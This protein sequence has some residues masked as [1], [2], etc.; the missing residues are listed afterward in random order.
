MTPRTT[1][2]ADATSSPDH[3]AGA[4]RRWRCPPEALGPDGEP[5]EAWT[6]HAIHEWYVFAL[7]LGRVLRGMVPGHR[8]ILEDAETGD[9]VQCAR[10]RGWFSEA[11]SNQYIEGFAEPL[12][13]GDM[14]GLR[15]LGWRPP[16]LDARALSPNGAPLK[17]PYTTNW[18]RR[19]LVRDTE[20][21]ADVAARTLGFVYRTG[22]P[23]TLRVSAFSMRGDPPPDL[24]ELC[25]LP[26]DD[27][28]AA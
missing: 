16:M 9:Y 28:D 6:A 1:D 11:R 4:R 2:D 20:A 8:L 17:R 21:L 25:E 22:L 13:A 27:D 15:H 14:A 18:W 24:G 23:A 7:R 12:T 3:D 26:S 19:D 10:E 5:I